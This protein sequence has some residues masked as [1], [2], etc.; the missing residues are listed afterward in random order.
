MGLFL[1]KQFNC[2]F[3]FFLQVRHYVW[4]ERKRRGKDI[5]QSN[6]KQKKKEKRVNQASMTSPSKLAQSLIWT[7]AGI[8]KWIGFLAFRTA[9]YHDPQKILHNKIKIVFVKKAIY[10]C[11]LVSL[12]QNQ[13]HYHQY[14][15][16]AATPT[17]TIY[18]K[19]IPPVNEI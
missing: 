17:I 3:F 9:I 1:N 6:D 19:P 13:H 11:P 14:L 8:V 7:R 5:F 15:I 16:E 10:N 2:F 4:Q 18:F 12:I